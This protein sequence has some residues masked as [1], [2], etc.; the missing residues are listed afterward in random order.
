M[1][2]LGR[3]A[4]DGLGKEYFDLISLYAIFL[5]EQ[6]IMGPAERIFTRKSRLKTGFGMFQTG[7]EPATFAL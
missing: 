1:V 5:L 4:S 7:I 2:N 6:K 3:N